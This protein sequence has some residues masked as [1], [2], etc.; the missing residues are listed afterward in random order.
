MAPETAPQTAPFT[1]PCTTA[2]IKSMLKFPTAF[3]ILL[4]FIRSFSVS[5]PDLMLWAGLLPTSESSAKIKK[6]KLLKFPFK[7]LESIQRRWR[8]ETQKAP[9]QI[10]LA[11][12]YL[13][14]KN[15]KLLKVTY[16]SHNSFF[17]NLNLYWFTNNLV[18]P[19]Q[20][21]LCVFIYSLSY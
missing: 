19:A 6:Y 8:F 9:V 5:A 20:I 3:K 7:R 10:S 16:F 17:I 13:I 18:W 11:P 21:S 1:A 4:F 15:F 2:F 12:F 14:V